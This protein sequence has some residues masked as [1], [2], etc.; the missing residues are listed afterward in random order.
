MFNG[1]LG[2]RHLA[3]DHRFL[4]HILVRA[5]ETGLDLGDGVDDAHAVYDFTEHGV[6]EAALRR[7]GE[8]SRKSLFTRLMKN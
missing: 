3:D 4:G 7:G 5:V 2:N 6:A 1:L 8:K